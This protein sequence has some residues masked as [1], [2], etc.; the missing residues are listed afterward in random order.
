MTSSAKKKKEKKK[1]FQKPKLKVGKSAPK[2]ANSTSTSFNA[3]KLLV[4]QQIK[5]EAPSQREQFLHHVSLLSSRTDSQRKESLA[6]LTTVLQGEYRTE[7]L[8]FSIESFLEKVTS[9]LLDS[10]Q[11][12]RNQAFKLVTALPQRDLAG[13]VFRMLPYIRAGLMH[14]SQDIRRNMLDVLS[15][16]L[17]VF[18]I[19]LVAAP[20]GWTKTTQCFANIL[21]F[22]DSTESE[23]W[24]MHK[25]G[26]REDARSIA[27]TLQVAEQFVTAGLA[28]SSS[29]QSSG[30]GDVDHP[31][32][33]ISLCMW[34]R[35][36]HCISDKSDPYGYLNLFGP[37]PDD[38]SRQLEDLEARTLEFQQKFY[39]RFTK[40]LGKAKQEG[41]E[42]GRAAGQLLKTIETFGGDPAD[43]IDN[44]I[45]SR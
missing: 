9:L 23:T 43:G 38:D 31:D 28:P 35:Q 33:Y 36:H 32:K 30:T 10:N 16:L 27:R 13:S 3:K 6:Y 8:P 22:K 26:F 24:S 4:N 18:S 20:G 25:T 19:E 29:K 14:L 40:S 39:S 41:G 42:V 7:H 11:G 44:D 5:S 21:G 34:D 12:V 15:Y 2:A 17:T 1:D 37:P 45:R